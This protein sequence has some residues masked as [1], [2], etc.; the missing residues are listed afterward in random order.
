M[1]HYE[2]YLE[3]EIPALMQCV[4]PSIDKE[5][6]RIA[7]LKDSKHHYR[8]TMITSLIPLSNYEQYIYKTDKFS[9]CPSN[10]KD[11]RVVDNF[12]WNDVVIRWHRERSATCN[13]ILTPTLIN[14]ILEDCLNS[15][16]PENL[17]WALI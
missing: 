2:E 8:C 1:A 9:M 3:H 10:F 4:I 11:F 17:R 13:I 15:L 7:Y 16:T 5:I 14:E 6:G 12:V